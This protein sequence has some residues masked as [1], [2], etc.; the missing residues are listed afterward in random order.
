MIFDPVTFEVK[1]VIDWELS[2]IG[3]PMC[4]LAMNCFSYYEGLSSK[5]PS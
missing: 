5:N 2:T 1:A 3:D 4:D